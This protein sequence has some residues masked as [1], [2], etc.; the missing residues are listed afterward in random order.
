MTHH[1][2]FAKSVKNVIMFVLHPAD[3]TAEPRLRPLLCDFDYFAV[4]VVP[5]SFSF[6]PLTP[7]LQADLGVPKARRE[8]HARRGRGAVEG[9]LRGKATQ[10]DADGRDGTP[11]N[12][13][14]ATLTI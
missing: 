14:E 1:F 11:P 3:F 9:K 8:H 5:C 10:G 12:C 4:L 6:S 13:Y 7:V 2:I